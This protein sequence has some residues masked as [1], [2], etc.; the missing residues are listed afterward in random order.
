MEHNDD[1]TCLDIRQQYVATG[2]LGSKPIICVWD[3][4]QETLASEY[5]LSGVLKDGIAKVIYINKLFSFSH[6]L[7]IINFLDMFE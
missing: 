6:R 5:I 4:T 3:Y 2:Q 7:I 1:I